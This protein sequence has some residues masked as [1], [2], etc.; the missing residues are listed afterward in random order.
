V[1]HELVEVQIILNIVLGRR[2]KAGVDGMEV[3]RRS[4]GLKTAGVSREAQSRRRP[5]FGSLILVHGFSARERGLSLRGLS[6]RSIIDH[7]GRF[8]EIVRLKAAA[9]RD[10]PAGTGLA[11]RIKMAGGQES[12][13]LY[14][15]LHPQRS[16]DRGSRG[17]LIPGVGTGRGV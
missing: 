13:G 8:G 1:D 7:P 4:P 14:S 11:D 16:L 6:G 9:G 12:A 3:E 15:Y 2:R 5:V 17:I 10:R